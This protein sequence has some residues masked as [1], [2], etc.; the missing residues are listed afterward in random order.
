VSDYGLDD[1]A[2]EVRSSVEALSRP[3]LRLTHPPIQWVMGGGAHP[4]AKA[5]PVRDAD[6]SSHLVPTSRMS[7]SYVFS[8]PSSLHGGSGTSLLFFTLLSVG[9]TTV[10][11]MGLFRSDCRSRREPKPQLAGEQRLAVYSWLTMH[12][13][14]SAVFQ[15]DMG[16]Q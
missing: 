5:L 4:G 9:C 3:V 1:R 10:C 11:W 15:C 7:R 14:G 16:Y 2:T 8:P 6:H 13:I 12:S